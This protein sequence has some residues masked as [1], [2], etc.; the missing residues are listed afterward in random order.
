M[1]QP[2][3]KIDE[4]ASVFQTIR[5]DPNAIRILQKMSEHFDLKAQPPHHTRPAAVAIMR[6][7]GSG[8]F[9]V[10]PTGGGR[11]FWHE[12]GYQAKED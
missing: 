9:D 12:P 1:G 3:T 2:E 4:V 10:V 6:G 8:D 7:I 5:K 11:G